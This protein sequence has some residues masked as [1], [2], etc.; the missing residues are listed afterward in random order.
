MPTRTADPVKYFLC[1]WGAGM[2]LGLWQTAGFPGDVPANLAALDRVADAAARGGADLLLCPECWL[3][4]Y[5]I[6]SATASLAESHDGAS[7][8]R[9]AGI[10]RR[11]SI[12]IAYGYAE[13]HVESGGIYNSV[14]VFGPDG[15][16]LSRYRKTHLFG[17]DERAAYT[18]GS[19]F[20]QPFRLGDLSFGLL[21]C[22]DVEFPEAVRS[23]A[24]LGADAILV[25]TALCA[26]YPQIPGTIVPARAVESQVVIAYCN[27]SGAEN[28]MRF[29]GGSCLVGA[30]GYAIAAAGADDRGRTAL[31]HEPH[32]LLPV[33]AC[34]GRVASMPT[35]TDSAVRL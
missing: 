15:A 26:E 1:E 10:A 28:G 2:K 25:P 9:V 11:S 30:D 14:Q 18:P 24:L 29:F 16:V 19:V 33:G 6:G 35:A 31:G 5:N 4:G 27:H 17:P 32:Q 23:L 7:A 12:A 3:C 22:Y 21:I 13:R 34:A 8:E 20:E